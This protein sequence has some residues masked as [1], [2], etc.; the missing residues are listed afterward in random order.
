M[1]TAKSEQKR[2]EQKTEK[3]ALD[4]SAG[5]NILAGI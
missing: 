5:R 2:Q 3:S 1:E 4:F